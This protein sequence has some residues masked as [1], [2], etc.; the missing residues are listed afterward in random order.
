[1]IDRDAG[2]DDRQRQ[3][4]T[5]G[6]RVV[7]EGRE[8]RRDRERIHADSLVPTELARDEVRDLREEET[9]AGGDCRDDE[10]KPQL[11]AFDAP[12]Q[13]PQR[14]TDADEGED[15]DKQEPGGENLSDDAEHRESDDDVVGHGR[16]LSRE[17]A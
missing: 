12:P 5:R 2:A 4:V 14:A 10:R 7:E 11:V 1:V 13:H 3:Q 9:A 6:A 17:R 8:Q 15:P 16:T